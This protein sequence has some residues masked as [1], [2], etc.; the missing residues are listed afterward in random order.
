M[1]IANLG[2]AAELAR[3]DERLER[4]ISAYREADRINVSLTVTIH[5]R[6]VDRSPDR[7]EQNRCEL[8]AAEIGDAVVDALQRRLATMRIELGELGVTVA[9]PAGGDEGRQ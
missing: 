3:E 1:D 5:A 4:T 6:G 2:K 9:A 7:V 8:A